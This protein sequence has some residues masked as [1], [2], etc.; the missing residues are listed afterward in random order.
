M[1]GHTR[2]LKTNQVFTFERNEASFTDFLSLN[3]KSVESSRSCGL[4][5]R[6]K[7][8]KSKGQKYWATSKA[9]VWCFQIRSSKKRVTTTAR[10]EVSK[11]TKERK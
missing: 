9:A 6:L 5:Y 8:A 11:F 7:N 10:I 1:K 3:S 2:V 4:R